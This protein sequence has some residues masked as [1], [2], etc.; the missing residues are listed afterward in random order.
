MEAL[1]DGILQ[2]SRAGRVKAKPESIDTGAMVKD[3]IELMA[4]PKTITITVAP[5]MPTVRAE[6]IPLQQVFMNL[7]GNAIKHAGSNEPQIGVSWEDAGPFYEFSVRDN[8]QGIAPQYHERIF[9]IFQTLEARDKV[10]G[11]GI[12][13]SVVQKI[14]EAKGGRV[15]VESEVGKGASFKFLW[16]K[17][18]ITGA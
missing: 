12:G 11:T 9:G 8:G 2:Y 6:K 1:I 7:L 17:V 18:E 16:P 14:V 10:E 13:L 3:V 4:P 15:W 5:G